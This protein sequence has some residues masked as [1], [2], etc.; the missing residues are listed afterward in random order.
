MDLAARYGG[1]EFAVVLPNCSQD[2][3]HD[4]AARLA[5]A[6]RQLEI[7][8]VGSSKGRVTVSIG[9][10]TT[11]EL[12]MGCQQLLKGCDEALYAAKSAGRDKVRAATAGPGRSRAL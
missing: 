4:V 10:W 3:A 8:H 2:E 1:E 11:D 5:N 6:V 9:L 7:P 12:M